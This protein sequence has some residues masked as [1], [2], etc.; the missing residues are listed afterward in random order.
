MIINNKKG[1]GIEWW[2]LILAVAVG[3]VVYFINILNPNQAFAN[4]IGQYQF[5]II[6]SANEAEKALLF[7]DQSAKYSLQQAVYELAK[8]GASVSEVY[9]DEFDTS[10]PF[11]ENDCEKFKD[12]YVWYT[13]KKDVSGSY[14][15]SNC[16]DDD[17]LN[18]NLL[19]FFNKNL[20]QYLTNSP[21]A[22]QPDNYDYQ[23]SN[24]L[25][26]IGKAYLPLNFYILKEEGKPVIK[27]TSEFKSPETQE[28]FVDF[29]ETELCAKGRKCLLT[30]DAYDL[31]LKAQE[32]ANKYKVTL[33][34]TYGY[35]TLEEQTRLWQKNPNKDLVCRPSP[36]CP[37][38]SGK[39][40]DVILKEKTDWQLLYKIMAEAGWVLYAQ[41][42]D[43]HHF[44]CCGTDRYSRA[45]A[46]GL[47]AIK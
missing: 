9:I 36:T 8:E 10:Q 5:S 43:E 25:E 39:V 14:T 22:I 31:L 44:E 41:K 32:I 11:V 37:H 47:T 6:N 1:A 45:K 33:Q 4:Y 38:L 18:T 23:V 15:K 16:I 40:V 12:A 42:G 46:Q 29:T 27:Q 3:A 24:G 2:F 19:Y 28:N 30:K 13:L 7:I 26:I 34:V 20:N 17:S 21:Y 35:R